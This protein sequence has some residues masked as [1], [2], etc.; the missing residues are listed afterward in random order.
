VA[1]TATVAEAVAVAVGR[2]RLPSCSS[3][4]RRSCQRF[5]LE[6]AFELARALREPL[7]IIARHDRDLSCQL[8][9]AGGS[10]ASCLSEGAQRCG[11]DR[12]HL[13][14]VSA[15]SAAEVR[16]QLQLATA[17]GYLDQQAR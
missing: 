12:L 16:T 1:V 5:A 11:K 10:V 2:G 14:R 8:R 13:Y 15:G 7:G 3:S 17:W 9:R 4:E 6:L